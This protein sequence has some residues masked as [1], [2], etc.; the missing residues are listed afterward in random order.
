ML[1]FFPAKIQA[2]VG[3]VFIVVGLAV[4]HSF[5]LAGVG[6]LGVAFGASRYLRSRRLNGSQR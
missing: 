5:L 6:V 2:V 4:L 1:F 3:V